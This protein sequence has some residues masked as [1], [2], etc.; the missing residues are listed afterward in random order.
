MWYLRVGVS[1]A[2]E[3]RLQIAFCSMQDLQPQTC[4]VFIVVVVLENI[5][6]GPVVLSKAYWLHLKP[7][8]SELEGRIQ[9][10][11]EQI[12]PTT[13][14][15]N[16][17]LV[18]SS[19]RSRS[20]RRTLVACTGSQGLSELG[21]KASGQHFHGFGFRRFPTHRFHNMSCSLN[22]SKGGCMRDY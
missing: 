11:P 13:S 21:I 14:G 18:W 5:R 8:N 12:R 22:S 17:L 15:V 6:K 20:N 3:G 10:W 9:A 19:N 4:A 2:S 1:R 7:V 16:E